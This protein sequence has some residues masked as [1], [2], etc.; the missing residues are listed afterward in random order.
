MPLEITAPTNG[1]TN[2]YLVPG[3][4]LSAS[5]GFVTTPS[6]EDYYYVVEVTP[7]DAADDPQAGPRMAPVLDDVIVLYAPW[8]A[9][10]VVTESE[11]TGD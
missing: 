5:G 11:V 4:D 10:R 9:A 7:T 8:S 1:V 6:G 2:G 3:R